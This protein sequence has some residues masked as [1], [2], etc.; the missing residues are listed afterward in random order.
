MN[1]LK[2][3]HAAL[4]GVVIVGFVVLVGALGYVYLLRSNAQVASTQT[5]QEAPAIE[6]VKDLDKAVDVLD[7]AAL[8]EDL[9]VLDSMVEQL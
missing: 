2:R 5:V 8:D 9:S 1:A 6:Q 3:G 7:A 4:A